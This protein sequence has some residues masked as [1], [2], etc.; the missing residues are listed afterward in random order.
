MAQTLARISCTKGSAIPC[1][2]ILATDVIYANVWTTGVTLPAGDV[3]TAFSYVY[4]GAGG[5][6]GTPPTNANCCRTRLDRAMPHHDPLRECEFEPDQ[7]FI[8]RTCGTP[9]RGSQP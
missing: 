7:G 6:T 3:D 1:S 9:P 8:F 5:I 2:Q 4:E